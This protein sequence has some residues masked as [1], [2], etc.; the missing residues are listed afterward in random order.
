MV[1]AV[2]SNL[3]RGRAVIED[4]LFL[5]EDFLLRGQDLLPFRPK[6]FRQLR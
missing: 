6:C 4:A 1:V 3:G 2:D 5:R